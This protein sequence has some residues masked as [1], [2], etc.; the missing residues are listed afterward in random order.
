[1]ALTVFEVPSEL[2]PSLELDKV[3]KLVTYLCSDGAEIINGATITAD[4]GWTSSY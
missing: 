2:M 4:G 3:A 1:M